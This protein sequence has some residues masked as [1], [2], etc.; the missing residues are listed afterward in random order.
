MQKK[1]RNSPHHHHHHPPPPLNKQTNK[2]TGIVGCHCMQKSP[3]RTTKLTSIHRAFRVHVSKRGFA[4]LPFIQK[5]KQ[6]KTHTH[7]KRKK[8]NTIVTQQRVGLPMVSFSRVCRLAPLL[9]SWLLAPALLLA[10][11]RLSS[12]LCLATKTWV[13]LSTNKRTRRVQNTKK[14]RATRGNAQR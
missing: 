14:E 3:G 4:R 6:N 7:Q 8:I 10:R 11:C 9:S 2:Q 13:V 1:A 5:H 12:P